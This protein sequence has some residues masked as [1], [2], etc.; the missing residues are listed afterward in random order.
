MGCAS[1]RLLLRYRACQYRHIG[2]ALRLA[3]AD[4]TRNACR[5]T[6]AELP[7]C[8]ASSNF[9]TGASCVVGGG[10]TKQESYRRLFKWCARSESNRHV[11]RALRLTGS[12]SATMTRESR[13][14]RAARIPVPPRARTI[15]QSNWCGRQDSNLQFAELRSLLEES[16]GLETR[17]PSDPLK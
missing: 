7:S 6:C 12:S 10:S 5:K 16:I 8:S 4:R 3:S 17:F 14:M 1:D 15:N 2:C 9:A 13:A 11:T